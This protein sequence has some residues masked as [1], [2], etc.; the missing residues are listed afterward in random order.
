[1]SQ[2]TSRTC[3]F[4]QTSWTFMFHQASL[5][6]MFHQTSWTFMFHQNS[7]TFMF[8]TLL[9]WLLSSLIVFPSLPPEGGGREWSSLW[10]CW[11][12]LR[13]RW[14]PPPSSYQQEEGELFR[15]M[16]VANCVPVCGGWPHHQPASLTRN[17]LALLMP[18]FGIARV[19]GHCWP[20]AGGCRLE[21]WVEWPLQ[22]GD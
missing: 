11:R 9:D 15:W 12:L 10:V 17:A 6:F 4:H 18:S 22:G 3:M 13:W 2:R 7:W 16:C 1:M 5:T 8:H 19:D 21:A 20:E 14:S